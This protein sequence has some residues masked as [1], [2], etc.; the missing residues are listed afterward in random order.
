MLVDP[1]MGGIRQGRRCSLQLVGHTRDTCWRHS[2]QGHAEKPP[3]AVQ[4]EFDIQSDPHWKSMTKSHQFTSTQSVFVMTAGPVDLTIAF[5][6]PV[7]VLRFI[8]R[9]DTSPYT[10][11]SPQIS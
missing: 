2:E 6:S 1:R 4:T 7:E 3:G 8:Y 10:L 11:P 5:L 9:Y